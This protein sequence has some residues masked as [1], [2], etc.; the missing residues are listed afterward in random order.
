MQSTGPVYWSSPAVQSSSP[1]QQSSPCTSPV[2]QSSP[3]CIQST[4]PVHQSSQVIVDYPNI[5][6]ICMHG[7]DMGIL[8]YLKYTTPLFQIYLMDLCMIQNPSC[9]AAGLLFSEPCPASCLQ[10]GRT[11]THLLFVLQVTRSWVGPA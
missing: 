2:Q 4:S 10:Y 3:P 8:N 9:I 7:C 11:L 5:G 6:I 1:V